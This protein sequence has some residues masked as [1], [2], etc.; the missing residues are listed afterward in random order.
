MK[1][2]GWIFTGI[3]VLLVGFFVWI[4]FSNKGTVVA[5]KNTSSAGGTNASG[6]NSAANLGN[7]VSVSG[8]TTFNPNILAANAAGIITSLG[9][10][11]APNNS[12]QA[13][14]NDNGDNEEAY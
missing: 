3:G 14:P 4:G 10:A 2:I 5:P 13:S 12:Q 8:T 6:N 7:G 9:T 11:F 1:L